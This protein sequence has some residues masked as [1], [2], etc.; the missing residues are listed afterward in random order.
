MISVCAS[1]RRGKL[2]LGNATRPGSTTVIHGNPREDCSKTAES[3]C[4]GIPDSTLRVP[5]KTRRCQKIYN[6]RCRSD[7]SMLGGQGSRPSFRT[8]LP[9]SPPHGSQRQEL[10]SELYSGILYLGMIMRVAMAF[11]AIHMT[12]L[13][14]ENFDIIP[15]LLGKLHEESNFRSSK[16]E[17]LM[18]SIWR[19]FVIGRDCVG[20]QENCR[21]LPVSVSTPVSRFGRAIRWL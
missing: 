17:F 15:Q 19:Q 14:T 21:C 2:K 8:I 3:W 12:G 7:S 1:R 10:I 6:Q 18:I 4:P 9:N 11:K 16:T 5:G 13:R 20:C